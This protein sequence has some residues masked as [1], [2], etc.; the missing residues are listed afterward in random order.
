MCGITGFLTNNFSSDKKMEIIV[1]NMAS[2]IMHRGPDDYGAWV[3]R[4]SR[5]ALGH[6]RLSILDLSVAGHQPMHSFN[7]RY[8]IFLLPT[9]RDVVSY[10][11]SSV[12]TIRNQE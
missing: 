2:R 10:V 12:N 9:Q 5:I 7:K 3:D 11:I 4:D 6:R 1:S 8:V